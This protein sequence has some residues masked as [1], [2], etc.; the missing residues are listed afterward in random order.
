MTM[1]PLRPVVVCV[2]AVCSRLVVAIGCGEY[3]RSPPIAVDGLEIGAG[4]HKG[5]HHLTT[6]HT[7]GGSG[8]V[9]GV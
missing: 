7:A 8:G 4:L 6:Q 9:R 2:P 3:E 1:P 5:H